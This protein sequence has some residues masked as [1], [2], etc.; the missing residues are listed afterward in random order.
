MSIRFASTACLALSAASAWGGLGED[1]F[2]LGDQQ[3]QGRPSQQPGAAYTR[4][5]VE[6]QSGTSVRAYQDRSGVI[7]AVGWSGPV[8]P[9]LRAVL[10][11]HFEAL[12]SHQRRP[13]PGGALIVRRPDLVVVSEGRLGAFQGRAWLPGSLPFGFEPGSLP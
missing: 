12:D 13:G 4:L 10:G 11:K 6:L 8:L 5:D 7:F 3:R 2:R 9:D 1:H